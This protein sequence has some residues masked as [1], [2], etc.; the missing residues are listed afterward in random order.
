MHQGMPVLPVTGRRRQLVIRDAT[1][2]QTLDGAAARDP[3]AEQAR[4]KDLRV[5][6]NEHVAPPEKARQMLD[7]RVGEGARVASDAQH[8]GHSAFGGRFLGDEL[9][10]EIEVEVADVHPRVMLLRVRNAGA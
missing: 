4:G 7:R 8:P 1:D 9:W 2:E 3:M 5:V 6:D 10:R